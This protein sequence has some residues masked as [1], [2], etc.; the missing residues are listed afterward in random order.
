MVITHIGT[1]TYHRMTYKLKWIRLGCKSKWFKNNS[2]IGNT[3]LKISQLQWGK[4]G[5]NLLIKIFS[6]MVS[7]TWNSSGSDG[8]AHNNS[9]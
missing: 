7:S 5:T 1:Y 9:N 2:S 6:K 8:Q 4:S 3:S